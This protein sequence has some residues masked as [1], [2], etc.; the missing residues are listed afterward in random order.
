MNIPKYIEFHNATNSILSRYLKA[1]EPAE[2]CAIL[3]GR[4]KDSTEDN[5]D[6]FWEIKHIW[7]CRNIWGQKESKL[8]DQNRY[9]SPNQTIVKLSTRNCFEIDP[10]DQIS[11]Q[12]WA[13]ENTLQVLCCAHSHPIGDNRPS[14]MDLFLH[15]SP[16]LMVISNNKGNLKAWWIK[17]KSSYW[18]VK[19]K[20][21][22]LT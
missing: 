15:Q 22:S 5:K 2:S 19:I 18:R 4:K 10:K 12:K 6:T 8:T 9:I 20:I 11:A 14:E 17:N 13:R 21:S 16:G 7:D 3:I 1:G